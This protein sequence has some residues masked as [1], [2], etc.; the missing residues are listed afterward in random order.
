MKTQFEQA[1][2]AHVEERLK[3]RRLIDW[4]REERVM[5][6]KGEERAWNYCRVLFLVFLVTNI[7]RS[8]L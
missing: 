8:C 7:L 3:D 1:D 2:E 4:L 5:Y 6:M